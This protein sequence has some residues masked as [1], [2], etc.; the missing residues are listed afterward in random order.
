MK[1]FDGLISGQRFGEARAVGVKARVASEL[2]KRI[3]KHQSLKLH[4]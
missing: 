3:I 1:D 2:Q 4:F